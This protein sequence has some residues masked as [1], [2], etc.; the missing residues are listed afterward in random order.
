MAC[1]QLP[2]VQTVSEYCASFLRGY[3]F[4]VAKAAEVLDNTLVILN[5]PLQSSTLLFD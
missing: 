2:R 5:G 4:D 1:S 3:K